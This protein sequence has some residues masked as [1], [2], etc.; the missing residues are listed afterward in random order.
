[1]ANEVSMK[2]AYQGVLVG[3]LL[4]DSIGAVWEVGNWNTTHPLEKVT[5][6]I[7]ELVKNK[8]TSPIA[9]DRK[10]KYTDDSAMTLAMARSFVERKGFDARDLARK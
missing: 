5:S 3:A 7:A 1:M 4:G 6:R 10:M 8:L 2:L 9:S